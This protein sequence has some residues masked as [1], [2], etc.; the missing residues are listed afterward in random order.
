MP[1]EGGIPQVQLS[2]PPAKI[3]DSKNIEACQTTAQGPGSCDRTFAAT[4][5]TAATDAAPISTFWV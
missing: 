4:R 3:S 1:A 2:S 5:Y